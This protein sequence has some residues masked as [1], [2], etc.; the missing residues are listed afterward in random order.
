MIKGKSG[1]GRGITISLPSPS[2]TTK[3]V[4]ELS[5]E[6]VKNMPRC[7]GLKGESRAPGKR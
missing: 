2:A 3:E 4:G 7:Q 5:K 6:R 1:K